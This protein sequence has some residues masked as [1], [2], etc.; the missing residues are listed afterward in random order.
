VLFG[1]RYQVVACL[2]AGG[3]GAVYGVVDTKTGRHRALKTMLP[4][5]LG[6]SGLRGRFELEAKI[7]AQIESEHIV[8]VS[9]AGVDPATDCPFLV[10]D[11]L[12]G[13][14]LG[15]VI[16]NDGPLGSADVLLL[17]W[18]ASLALEKTHAAEIVHR[19][20][21]PENLFLTLRDDS[22]ARLKILDFGIAKV[23]AQSTRAKT[24]H[25][26]GTPFYMAPEQITGA[27]D[28]DPRAD[29]YALGHIAFTLLTAHPYW[30]PESQGQAGLFAVL[31]GIGSGL[32]ETAV[33][34]ARRYGVTLPAQFDPWF[35]RATARDIAQRFDTATELVEELAV[36]LE[37]TVPRP[38]RTSSAPAS[39]WARTLQASP[40]LITGTL[41]VA[42]QEA[43]A[44]Q[45]AAE[46][47]RG[48]RSLAAVARSAREKAPGSW[49]GKAA[50]A[51]ALGA[52]A[53]VALFYRQARSA[54]PHEVA[55][56]RA[57]ASQAAL[58]ALAPAV[59][60]AVAQTT[61][62]A[63]PVLPA[64]SSRAPQASHRQRT[65]PPSA[66]PKLTP[67]PA[68]APSS[69]DPAELR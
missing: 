27:G 16:D 31:A 59:V 54:G 45:R 7:T 21:K 12:R 14:D 25:R 43:G 44:N 53:G 42:Q 65:P 22:S 5:I 47:D 52:G 9:D 58:A 10:M 2:K 39:A 26:V 55:T 15:A 28:I 17:L 50:V 61:S 6:D 34:R 30:E 4:N 13:R 37:L 33:A 29:L 38:S 40:G 67:S 60:P 63:V 62:V 35:E 48:Q 56:P 69:Q 49:R 8:D 32:P 68:T 24:T 23:V 46:P 1:E 11:L 41:R 57:A 3:M 51:L 66:H 20:L 64:A 18:Q 19:D 36:A